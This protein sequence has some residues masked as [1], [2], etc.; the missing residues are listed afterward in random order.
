MF[1]TLTDAQRSVA[2]HMAPQALGRLA[3]SGVGVN[4]GECSMCRDSRPVDE[5]VRIERQRGCTQLS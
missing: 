2:S 5:M 4:I 3:A 1:H